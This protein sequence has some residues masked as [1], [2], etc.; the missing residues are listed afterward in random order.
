VGEGVADVV[1]CGLEFDGDVLGLFLGSV[2]RVVLSE[3]SS[4]IHISSRDLSQ[5]PGVG[6]AGVDGSSLGVLVV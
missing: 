1:P 3:R 2:C 6:A 5:L 4:G